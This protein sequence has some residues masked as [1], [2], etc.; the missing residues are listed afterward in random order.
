MIIVKI[1]SDSDT[2]AAEAVKELQNVHGIKSLDLVIANAGLSGD[3]PRIEDARV[4][5]MQEYYNVNV[6]GVIVLFKAVLPLLKECATMPKLIAMGSAAGSIGGMED[7]PIPNANYGP[8]KAGLN[9]VMRK[10][11][12]EHEE[13]IAFPIH[14]GWVIELPVNTCQ[15]SDFVIGLHRPRLPMQLRGLLVWKRHRCRSTKVLLDLR[16]W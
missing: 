5:T 11:H 6:I 16:R 12:M 1:R 14:P 2:D 8:V 10:I 13:F 9:W 15:S 3:C 4:T 7:A